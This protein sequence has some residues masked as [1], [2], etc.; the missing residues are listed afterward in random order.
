M[1]GDLGRIGSHQISSDGSIFTL[2]VCDVKQRLAV[3]GP[4]ETIG[5]TCSAAVLASSSRTVSVRGRCGWRDAT[6]LF[7][8]LA[9]DLQSAQVFNLPPAGCAQRSADYKSAIQQIKNLRCSK[10]LRRQPYSQAGTS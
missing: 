9:A 4:I 6:Y 1:P 7:S 8:V 5:Q 10:Q 2:T 3:R